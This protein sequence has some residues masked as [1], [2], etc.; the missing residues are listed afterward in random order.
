MSNFKIPT[1]I[2][3]GLGTA[4]LLLALIGSKALAELL[5]D[6]GQTSEELFRGDRLPTLKISTQ[7][8]ENDEERG[9]KR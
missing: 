5:K 8:N 2:L 3:L 6:V 7:T 1:Q 4:P 9:E